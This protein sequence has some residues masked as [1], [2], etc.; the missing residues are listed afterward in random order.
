MLSRIASLFAILALA[1]APLPAQIRNVGNLTTREISALDRAKTVVILQGGMLEEHGP[2]L[3]AFTDGILSARLATALAEGLVARMPGWTIL[4]FPPIS[5]GTSGYNE[6]SGRS[7]FPGTYAVRP[8]VLRAAFMDLASELGDQGFR[9]IL[10]VHVHGS[11]LHIN[12]LDQASDYFHDTYGGTM[13]NL[14]GLVPVLAGWGSALGALPD[15]VKREDGASLHAGLDEHSMMLYL[16]PTLVASDYRTAPTIAGVNADSGFAIARRPG[17]PGYI[18]APRLATAEIGQR[19]WDGFAAA[20]VRVAAEI[21]AGKNPATYTRYMSI[22]RNMPLYRGWIA[23]A[24][25][26]D[27]LLGE[28]QSDWLRRKR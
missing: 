1:A 25:Q 8:S 24:E 26:R 28:R 17:W 20:T 14:W 10:V 16:A 12:A 19:I 21:L 15:S 23:T 7:V 9:W 5:V 3:P 4:V 27:S 22:L 6:I 11:P 2:Y 13:V 18:G